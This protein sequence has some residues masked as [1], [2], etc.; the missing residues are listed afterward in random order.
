MKLISKYESSKEVVWDHLQLSSFFVNKKMH[1]RVS[2]ESCLLK[3][4]IFHNESQSSCQLFDRMKQIIENRYAKQSHNHKITNNETKRNIESVINSYQE[5]KDWRDQ[6]FEDAN[7]YY[8]VNDLK[9]RSNVRLISI[10]SKDNFVP[11]LIDMN[12]LI[13]PISKDKGLKDKSN[14]NREW[15][16]ENQKD[17]ILRWLSN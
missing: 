5:L 10:K 3:K 9:I 2:K 12:H 17:E 14:F 7:F 8:F 15:N 11:I 16:L 6:N 1:N 4:I 13:I